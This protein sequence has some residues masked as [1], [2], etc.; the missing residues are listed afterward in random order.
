M[1]LIILILSRLFSNTAFLEYFLE[2]LFSIWQPNVEEYGINFLIRIYKMLHYFECFGISLGTA[3]V[4]R[5]IIR[6]QTEDGRKIQL[7]ENLILLCL[8]ST[9]LDRM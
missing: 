2:L 5:R 7:F 6:Y 1:I 8:V 4:W 3:F 9:P